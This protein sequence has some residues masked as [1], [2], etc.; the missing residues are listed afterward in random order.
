MQN[1]RRKTKTAF[2]PLPHFGEDLS[3]CIRARECGYE[4]CCDPTI[5]IGHVG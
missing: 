2:T 3:F 4:I 1:N 5:R